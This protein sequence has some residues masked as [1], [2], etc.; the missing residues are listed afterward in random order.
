MFRFIQPGD[1][2]VDLVVDLFASSLSA[3]AGCFRTSHHWVSVGCKRDPECFFLAKKGL[4]KQFA[5]AA[6]DASINVSFSEEKAD[7]N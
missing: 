2:V 4:L 7:A 1:L 6:F 5:R 3:A